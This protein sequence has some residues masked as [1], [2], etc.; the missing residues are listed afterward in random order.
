MQNEVNDRKVATKQQISTVLI[1]LIS[2]V[3]I[4]VLPEMLMT[5]DRPN[6]GMS[7]HWWLYS[8]AALMIIIFYI[9]YLWIIDSTLLKKHR[10]VRFVLWNVLLIVI[11]ATLMQWFS[12]IGHGLSTHP[13]PG[14]IPPHIHH[15]LISFPRMW[16]DCIML[17][18]TV[19]LSLAVRLS[20]QWMIFERYKQQLIVTQREG[21]LNGL[22][23][24]L[25][26]HFL[27]NTLN[28]IYALI[29]ISPQKAQQ[30]VH[31]LSQLLRY[32]VYENPEKVELSRELEYAAKYIELMKLRM[33]ERPINVEITNTAGQS[34]EVAPLV[35][36]TL[37][38]NA[39][40]HGNTADTTQPISIKIT[41]DDKSLVCT[42]VN[43]IAT[44]TRLDGCSGVGLTNLR[45]RLELI[46]GDA[47]S[48][49]TEEIDDKYIA[50]LQITLS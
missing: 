2:V 30:A 38:E 24:Q 31:D 47:A 45:R 46:Y 44:S 4:F 3:L 43:S 19:S 6:R 29:E 25:N 37:I 20:N 9:N 15:E 40:K 39:F 36:M 21:E 50:N 27:F 8:K 13:H 5:F 12:H 28:N 42:T 18:L 49:I 7:V 34:T 11:A 23:S 1:H 16:R 26:P 48:L 22:R 10:W 14:K 41:A 32:L 35:L 17:V 33:G